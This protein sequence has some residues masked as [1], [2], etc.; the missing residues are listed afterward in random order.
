MSHSPSF[1]SIAE[2]LKIAVA[3]LR[4]SGL[5]FV[6]GGSLAAWARGGPE[7]QNDLDFMIRPQDAEAALKA[8]AD[9]GMRT[10]RPPE[11]WL[12]KVWND[13]TLIDLIFCPSGLEMNDEVFDRS[14]TIAVLAVATPVMAIDDVMTTKLMALDEHSLDYTSLLLIARAVREQIDWGKLRR[15]TQ[16][17]PYAQAFFTLVESLDVAPGATHRRPGGATDSPASHVRVVA[18]GS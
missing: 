16:R 13:E 8:F 6:L 4:G 12:F 5:P 2:T 7:P 18:D 1:E 10:E 17:S 11:E 9:A 3:T 15:R 14:D